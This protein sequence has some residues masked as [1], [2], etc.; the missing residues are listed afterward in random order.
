[1]LG[2]VM[3]RAITSAGAFFPTIFA[4]LVLIVLHWLIAMLSFHSDWLGNYVKGVPRLL[5]KEGEIDWG[6][7]RG[8][9]V[10]R[11]DL[12]QSL[13]QKG[14]TGVDQVREARLERSGDISVIKRSGEPR[15]IDISVKD[16]V[17]TVRIQI[18][19][20]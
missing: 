9:H 1:M 15:I 5:V 10:S 20:S 14:L 4:G 12:L 7:M 13:R 19:A 18:D 6:E 8:G 3:S 2:S 11:N 16:G 17:Q